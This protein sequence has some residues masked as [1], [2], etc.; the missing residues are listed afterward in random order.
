MV[1]H[2]SSIYNWIVIF[3]K[4]KVVIYK[5]EKIIKCYDNV[6]V[7]LIQ[8]FKYLGRKSYLYYIHIQIT[9]NNNYKLVL[10][11]RNIYVFYVQSEKSYTKIEISSF[12]H[13]L[14]VFNLYSWLRFSVLRYLALDL[15]H[16]CT[17]LRNRYIKCWNENLWYLS[18]YLL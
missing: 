1:L 4:T 12:F 9:F 11:I 18:I 8:I 16:I 7:M 6:K 2:D 14:K 13:N 3:Y 15:I 5:F 10:W 17:Y